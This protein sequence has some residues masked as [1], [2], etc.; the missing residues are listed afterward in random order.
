MKHFINNKYTKIYYAIIEKAKTINR[1]DEYT[2]KHHIIPKSLGGSNEKDNLVALTGREHF[3]CHILL[4]KML[5]GPLRKKMIFAA[6]AMATLRRPDQ[7]RYK[8][9]A[10]Q[11]ETL[12][13]EFVNQL[14]GSKS[15]R[16]SADFTPEWREN[17]S[18]AK[19]GKQTW[20][21]GITHSQATRDKISK[22][23]KAKAGTPGWNVRP[24]CSDEKAAKIKASLMGKKWVNNG[25]ERKYASPEL[26]EELVLQGWKYGLKC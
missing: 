5:E 8:L 13:K 26:A 3:I 11:Y 24:P 17:L 10:R 16:T 15:S 14:T 1:L 25:S 7:Y 12:R 23:R 19:K 2:E 4:T 21:K 22:D 9:T 20:N 18:K 6:W